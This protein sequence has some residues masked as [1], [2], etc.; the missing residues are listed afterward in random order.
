[1][2][3]LIGV[4]GG[5]RTRSGKIH[6]T[7]IANNSDST[8]PESARLLNFEWLESVKIAERRKPFEENNKS[9][10]GSSNSETS[11]GVHANVLNRTLP[12][13]ARTEIAANSE[14]CEKSPNARK[15]RTSAR[16]KDDRKED[17]VSAKISKDKAGN[18][19][20]QDKHTTQKA[21]VEK[22][23]NEGQLPKLT[24]SKGI[25]PSEQALEARRSTANEENCLNSAPSS[26]KV[27]DRGDVDY[28]LGDSKRNKTTVYN[29]RARYT[30]VISLSDDEG[31]SREENGPAPKEKLTEKSEG[32]FSNF[33]KSL[34]EEYKHD[35][36]SCQRGFLRS[37]HRKKR[38]TQTEA[39]LAKSKADKINGT[40]DNSKAQPDDSRK[41]VSPKKRGVSI[42]LVALTDTMR[43]VRDLGHRFRLLFFPDANTVNAIELEVPGESNAKNGSKS[44]K[45]EEINGIDAPKEQERWRLN[46]AS[47]RSDVMQKMLEKKLDAV[48]VDGAQYKRLLGKLQR[49][50]ILWSLEPR[51]ETTDGSGSG[52]HSV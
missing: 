40:A 1:M 9:D 30:S 33:E 2:E 10:R 7:K 8:P 26:S 50:G 17:F 39:L 37:P 13:A 23:K 34:L 16:E 19:H 46:P 4:F 28:F 14:A 48:E 44:K 21:G 35:L 12:R 45:P 49:A 36:G 27:H 29:Q 51:K 43:F 31:K 47:S 11:K 32:K 5:G 15:K 52:D 20:G 3:E 38:D 6:S 24:D 41:N 18:S 22:K 42:F 25:V